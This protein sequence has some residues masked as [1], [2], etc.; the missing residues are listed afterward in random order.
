MGCRPTFSNS[1]NLAKSAA[2]QND[3]SEAPLLVEVH[4]LDFDEDIYDRQFTVEFLHYMRPEQ[5]FDSVDSLI[6]QISLDC[7]VLRNYL[8]TVKNT[9]SGNQGQKLLAQ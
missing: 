5:K 3:H 7:H 6:S 8:E 2:N 9:P 1:E 4:I